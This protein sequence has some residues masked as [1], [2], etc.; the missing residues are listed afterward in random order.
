MSTWR[1]VALG[2]ITIIVA[3]IIMQR[4]GISASG[5]GCGR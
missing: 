2:V 1:V 4:A 3:E 5:C